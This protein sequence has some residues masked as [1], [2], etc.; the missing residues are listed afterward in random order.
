MSKQIYAHFGH[1]HFDAESM[2][3][4][5]NR[6]LGVK[7]VGGIWASPIDAEYG[8]IDWNETEQFAECN[9]DNA[10]GF[11]L[12]D[13]ARVLQIT[14]HG[15]LMQ[16]AEEY[17]AYIPFGMRDIAKMTGSVILDFEELA[18]DYDAIEVSIS[19][20]RQLYHDLYGWDCDSILVMNPDVVEEISRDEFLAAFEET[21]GEY[22]EYDIDD[23]DER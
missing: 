12:S 22:D 2:D 11:T 7:P 6:T 23:D 9:L 15:Q 21:H 17:E 1:D 20:D 3:K 16:I 18:E 10:F 4:I 13:G 14:S 5:Q 19:S 8:W